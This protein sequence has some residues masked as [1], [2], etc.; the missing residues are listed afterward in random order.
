[1]QIGGWGSG[2]KTLTR[3]I[4]TE[5]ALATLTAAIALLTIVW[6]DWI[7]VIFGVDPDGGNGALEWGFVGLSAFASLMFGLR[8]RADLIDR[9]EVAGQE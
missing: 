7:E 9:A 6:P 5:T 1:M 3:R 4:W 8:A 2:S